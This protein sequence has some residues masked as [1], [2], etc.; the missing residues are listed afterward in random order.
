VT[1]AERRAEGEESLRLRLPFTENCDTEYNLKHAVYS[2]IM[3]NRIAGNYRVASFSGNAELSY[4][5]QAAIKIGISI[6]GG[7]DHDKDSTITARFYLL[8]P[9]LIYHF[10]GRGKI[11]ASYTLTSVTTDNLSQGRRIPHTMVRGR[12]EGENHDISLICDYRLSHRMNFVATYTGRRF[13]DRD[14]EHFAHT[15]LRAV[16]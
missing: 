14:F 3:E 5:P 13:A 1:G 12:K 4:Y 2:R 6:G 16:F 7:R 15:Q 11:E 9:S 8:K 10:S